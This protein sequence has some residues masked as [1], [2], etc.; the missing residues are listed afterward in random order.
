MLEVDIEKRISAMD[1]LNHVWIQK[2]NQTKFI[3]ENTLKNIGK[4]EVT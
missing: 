4:F 2:N 1:A 3:P